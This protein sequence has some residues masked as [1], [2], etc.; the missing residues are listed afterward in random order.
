MAGAHP[1]DAVAPPRVRRQR[2]GAFERAA[3]ALP[4]ARGAGEHPRLQ[5]LDRG[6]VLPSGPAPGARPGRPA[7]RGDDSEGPPSPPAGIVDARRPRRRLIRAR[8]RR[9]RRRAKEGAAARRLLREA[10]LRHRRA[11]GAR[12]RPPRRRGPRRAALPVPGGG[13]R[14]RRRVLSAGRRDRLGP[15]RAAEHGRVADDPPPPRSAR[16]AAPL[17][18]SAVARQPE[19]GLPDGPSDRAGPDRSRSAERLSGRLA[20]RWCGASLVRRAR[21]QNAR[22]DLRT[23]LAGEFENLSALPRRKPSPEVPGSQSDADRAH[24]S[25]EDGDAA[26]HARIL[27]QPPRD[28]QRSPGG[29]SPDESIVLV[30]VAVVAAVAM[31]AVVVVPVAAVLAVV[32]MAVARIGGRGGRVVLV[33]AVGVAVAVTCAVVVL[34]V[35]AL[36]VRRRGGRGR[37]GNRRSRCDGR[38]CRLRELAGR[39]RLR[40]RRRRRGSRSGGWGR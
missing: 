16:R 10:L 32:P 12:G 33:V 9:S 22:R 19:R 6:A 23:V 1:T 38:R 17:C 13:V 14:A 20:T 7:A 18:R 4:P 11:R 28:T 2:A 39:C 27:A 15:G 37:L 8:S 3:R 24:A 26:R 35:A 21:L 29:P 25:A 40:R 30:V 5:L 36:V 34:V 31:L